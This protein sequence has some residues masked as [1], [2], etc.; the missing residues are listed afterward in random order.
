[1]TAAQEIW[2]GLKADDVQALKALYQLYQQDL[3]QY[4]KRMTKDEQL[5]EDALQDTFLS[6]WKYRRTASMPT[7][8][9]PYM[10]KVFR[11]ELLRLFRERSAMLYTDESPE[12]SFEIAFD[13]KIVEGEEAGKLSADINKAL[14]QLTSRQRELIYYRF[15]E[16]LSF[17]EIAG[18]MNMQT[19]ATYKLAARALAALR[20][21]M[22]P[23]RFKLLL[24]LIGRL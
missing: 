24:V 14:Q 4:G 20:E 16:N 12:F 17:E 21:V 9:K 8:L 3:F 7:A 13:Q 15:Y 1:L 23:G 22:A 5:I 10:L 11:N 18:L 6:L 19:R 2:E